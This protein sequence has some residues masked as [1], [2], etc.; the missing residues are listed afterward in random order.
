[1]KKVL[2][3]MVSIVILGLIFAGCGE[4]TNITAPGST[5]TGGIT[6]LTKTN[7]GPYTEADPFTTDL[8]AGQNNDVGEVQVW[9]DAENLYI[10]YVID[11]PGWFLTETHLHVACSEGEIPQTKKGNPIPGQFEYSAE[12]D[13]L[14]EYP[15]DPI[16]LSSIECCIP[17]IAAHAVVV[18]IAEDCVALYSDG[19]ETF[20]AYTGSTCGDLILREGTAELAWEP[21]SDTD[22]SVWDSGVDYAFTNADWIWESYRTVNP[23]CGDVVDFTKTFEIPGLYLVWSSVEMHVTC[24]NGYEFL[25]NGE[26]Q[27][28]AQ[29]SAGWETS[30]LT[31]SFVN[32]DTWQ[33]VE[34]Y[35]GFAGDLTIGTNTLLF[36][37]ANE[38]MGTLDGQEAG[39]E[40]SNPAGLIYEGCVC[41]TVID[42]ED[43]AWGFGTRF[44]V[45]G[46]WGTY[47]TYPVQSVLIETIDI[48]PSLISGVDSSNILENGAGY[49]FVVSGEWNNRSFESVD[50]K[51]CS[52][53]G[54]STPGTEAPGLPGGPYAN[55]LLELQVN[56][57]FKEWGEYSDTHTYTIGFTGLGSAVNFAVNDTYYGDNINSTMKV[58]IWKKCM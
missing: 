42:K 2:F 4:I 47:F 33:S 5:T 43:T 49:E 37:A 24:D 15:L 28:S 55:T 21:Y 14:T 45:K 26:S 39:T 22:P 31:Q 34:L 35:S 3:L 8:L 58:E 27:G 9:N 20:E 18:H 54:W 40:D 30:D 41:Y 13:Y 46:N 50:A 38:Y 19:T 7:G 25:V 11:A 12:H 53:D 29:L 6:Y 16:P 17:F 52:S 44:V 36:K 23:I 48:N 32:T 57:G 1:M 10:T 56:G 51:Y